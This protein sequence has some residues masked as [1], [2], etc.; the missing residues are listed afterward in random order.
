[1]YQ[2]YCDAQLL[3]QVWRKILHERTLWGEFCAVQ[4]LVGPKKKMSALLNTGV[5]AFQGL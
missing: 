2:C 5:F 3:N 1:M 4:V